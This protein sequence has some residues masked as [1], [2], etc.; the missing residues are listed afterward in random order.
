MVVRIETNG[1]LRIFHGYP[2]RSGCVKNADKAEDKSRAEFSAQAKSMNVSAKLDLLSSY[3]K[4]ELPEK[5]TDAVLSDIYKVMF[6]Y[7]PGLG[8]NSP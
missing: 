1:T 4:A 7:D 8:I 2:G 5:D 6:M 3:F